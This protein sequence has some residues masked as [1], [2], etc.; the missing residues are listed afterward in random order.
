MLTDFLD[1]RI[2]GLLVAGTDACHHDTSKRQW[3][4]DSSRV[5]RQVVVLM[6]EI[7]WLLVSRVNKDDA[8][9]YGRQ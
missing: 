4:F 1:R 7:M 5:A 3:R 2:V 8:V 6:H 9:Q